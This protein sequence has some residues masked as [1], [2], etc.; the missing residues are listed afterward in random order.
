MFISFNEEEAKFAT[1]RI[2]N[3]TKH[4]MIEYHQKDYFQNTSV[5]LPESDSVFSWTNPHNVDYKITCKFFSN[6]SVD[7]LAPMQD[8]NSTRIDIEPDNLELNEK[9]E[10]PPHL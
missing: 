3:R 4:L 9:I 5:L 2:E 6:G 8:Y 1:Y 7:E 10:L